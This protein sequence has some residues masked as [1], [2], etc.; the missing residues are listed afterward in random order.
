MA[1]FYACVSQAVTKMLG[2][3]A[4]YTL[5]MLF[6]YLTIIHTVFA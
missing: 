5:F 4:P 1:R 2:R 6:D 3:F